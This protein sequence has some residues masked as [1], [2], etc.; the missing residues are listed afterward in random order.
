MPG[1]KICPCWEEIKP[2]NVKTGLPKEK[3]MKKKI[4]SDATT[5][6]EYL[7]IRDFIVC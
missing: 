5:A 6:G 1:N 3:Y 4:P 2:K 7:L